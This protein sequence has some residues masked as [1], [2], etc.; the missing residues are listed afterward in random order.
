MKQLNLMYL[1]LML[2]DIRPEGRELILRYLRT[3]RN[4][5]EN[6]GEMCFVA[7][8]QNNSS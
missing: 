3:T 4:K 7:M 2:H 8:L 6:N 5:I 1:N